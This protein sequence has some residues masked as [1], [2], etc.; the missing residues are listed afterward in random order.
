MC[1]IL[2]IISNQ[3][4]CSNLMLHYIYSRVRECTCSHC[5]VILPYTSHDE[6]FCA[7]LLIISNSCAYR[8]LS[9]AHT[10]NRVGMYL[11]SYSCKILLYTSHDI[12]FCAILFIISI[13]VHIAIC[14]T[15]L[16]TM[17]ECNCNHCNVILQY[18]LHDKQFCAMLFCCTHLKINTF[19]QYFLIISNR[20]AYSNLNVALKTM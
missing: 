1:A 3:C 19:V 15:T 8:Y 10:D 2:F 11:Q 17:W 14:C 18:A 20:S 5:N 4:A 13:V 7:I 6:Q 16:I 12:H 9:V